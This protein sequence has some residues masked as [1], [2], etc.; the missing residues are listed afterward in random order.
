MRKV[1]LY[2]AMTMDGL[3]ADSND[4][5]SFLDPYGELKWVVDKNNAIMERTDTILMGRSTY[6]VVQSFELPWPYAE[7]Q[8]FVW[9]DEPFF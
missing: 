3:I 4:G 9:S 7:H 1:L 2:I 8:C 6:E 5:E